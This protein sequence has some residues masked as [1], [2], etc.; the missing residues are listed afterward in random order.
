MSKIVVPLA[1]GFEE[2]EAVSIIDVCRRA[3]IEVNVAG[4]E[5]IDVVGANQIR[6]KCDC[7][8]SDINFDNVDMIVL[9]GGWGGTNVLASNVFVQNKL[10]EFKKDNKYIGAICAAPFALHRAGVLNENYTC[11]PSVEDQIRQNG[12]TDNKKV[13]I[14]GK[15]LTSRGPATAICFS[16]EIVKL[17]EGKEMYET[18]KGGLLADF[19]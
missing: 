17:L 9:P 18:L 7:L 3:G 19:C 6:I 2:I 8:F 12:Y 15:V 1:S 16:L 14:D 11:Y 4:I 13:V 10:K 5:T